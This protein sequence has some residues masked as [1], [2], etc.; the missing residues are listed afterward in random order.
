MIWTAMSSEDEKP[1]YKEYT[2]KGDPEYSATDAICWDVINRRVRTGEVMSEAGINTYIEHPD[3]KDPSHWWV[4]TTGNGGYIPTAP[5]GV[6]QIQA[7]ADGRFGLDDRTLHPQMYVR[8]FEYICCI[9]KR[10]ESRRMLWWTPTMADC[11]AVPNC[12]FSIAIRVLKPN[13]LQG[14]K[15]VRDKYVGLIGKRE[16]PHRSPL[17]GLLVTT[18]CQCLDKLRSFGMTYKE[19]LLAVAEFQRAVLDIHAWIDY[20]D[21]YQPRLYPGPNG[22]VKYDP[23]Q[24]LMGAFT[25]KVA[26]A[27]Q[28]HAMGIPVW[29]IRPCFR[30]LPTMNVG[31]PSMQQHCDTVVL[32]HFADGLGNP[33]P[34]PVLTAGPPSTELYRWTQRIGCAIMD[35][36]DVTA[37]GRQDFIEGKVRLGA[38]R[39]SCR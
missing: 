20:V 11:P 22:I 19:I 39:D 21:V 15:E 6:R 13:L 31:G 8:G 36:Q 35:V 24:N 18:M 4:I 7:R 12:P 17:A 37:I 28:L 1:Y 38:V 25:E 5:I 3:K 2:R 30:I 26:V 34:Y 9:P 27:Q 33:D 10:D 29:L 32:H 16:G 14:Y 23:N